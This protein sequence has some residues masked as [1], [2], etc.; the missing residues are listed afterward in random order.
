VALARTRAALALLLGGLACILIGLLYVK[1]DV[2]PPWKNLG[3]EVAAS[4]LLLSAG[5]RLVRHRF[6]HRVT[7]WMPAFAFV[8]AVL[9][10]SGAAPWW[11]AS[12]LSPLLL[13]FAVNHLSESGALCQRMLS[14]PVLT[15][16][17]VWS[18][19]LYLWQQPFYL[20]KTSF[21]GGAVTAFVCAMVAALV[22]YYFLEKPARSWLNLRWR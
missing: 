1:F 3:T 9:C 21:P 16:F 10:Y 6:S 17:G 22:S 7:P 20:A 4:H 18:Y 14:L 8:A 13:A 11:A 12:L 15:H 5:Y 19:S 2:I